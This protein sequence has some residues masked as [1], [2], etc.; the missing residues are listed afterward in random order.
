MTFYVLKVLEKLRIVSDVQGVPRH[1][2]DEDLSAQRA[3]VEALA[4]AGSPSQR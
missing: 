2:R 1:V 4:T 3:R